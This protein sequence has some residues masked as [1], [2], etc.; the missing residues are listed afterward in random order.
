MHDFPLKW[1]EGI[2]QD[3]EILKVDLYLALVYNTCIPDSKSMGSGFFRDAIL[4][5]NNADRL[6]KA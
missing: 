2:W 6:Y 5:W 4:A 3:Q 1:I